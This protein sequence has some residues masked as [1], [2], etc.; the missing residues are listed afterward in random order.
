MQNNLPHDSIQVILWRPAAL[1]PSLHDFKKRNIGE[2]EDLI[3]AFA[4]VLQQI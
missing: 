4:F 3:I 2:A 1:Q